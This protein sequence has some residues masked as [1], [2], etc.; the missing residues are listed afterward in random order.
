MYARYKIHISKQLSCL[1]CTKVCGPDIQVPRIVEE[2]IQVEDR[3][4]IR[5]AEGGSTNPV[6]DVHV[7]RFSHVDSLSE[8]HVSPDGQSNWLF[9]GTH[10]RL[11]K[12]LRI[13][14]HTKYCLLA[15]RLLFTG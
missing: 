6:G 2:G 4:G 5:R 11:D 9:P 8:R 3:E 12:L 10:R 13:T 14:D 15:E 1:A 7:V